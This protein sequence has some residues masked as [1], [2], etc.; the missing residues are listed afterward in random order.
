MAQLLKTPL[1]ITNRFGTPGYGF[2]GKHAGVDL[3]AAVGTPFY[4]PY[5]GVVNEAYIGSKGNVVLGVVMDG[6]WW[7]FLHLKDWNIGSG[8]SFQAGDLLGHAGDSGE[9]AAH[10]HVDVRKAGTAWNQSF[11]YYVDPMP[12]I[13]ETEEM[14]ATEDEARLA[15]KVL[16]PNGHGSLAEVQGTAG[17]RSYKE[18]MLSSQGEVAA[19]DLVIR[20]VYRT[21]D[22][23]RAQLKTTNAVLLDTATEKDAVIL[24]I[25]D[26]LN[27]ANKTILELRRD[28]P[29]NKPVTAPEAVEPPK[30]AKPKYGWFT[31]LIAALMRRRT[32]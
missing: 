13:K 5:D 3:R 22:D 23:L 16:R 14:I 20:D 4:A 6:K 15:Y 29:E 28:L 18:F 21:V 31:R 32:A 24:A 2:F 8:S 1:V 9:V 25:R 19:R 10:L 30:A 17:K 27:L 11:D 7:R 26:E 12:L